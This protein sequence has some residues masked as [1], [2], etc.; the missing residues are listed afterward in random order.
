MFHKQ[1]NPFIIARAD[2]P[3]DEN[4]I[5]DTSGNLVPTAD[6]PYTLTFSPDYA[7]GPNQGIRLFFGLRYQLH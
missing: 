1:R 2:D 5:F 3:F 7:S 4:V 6:N